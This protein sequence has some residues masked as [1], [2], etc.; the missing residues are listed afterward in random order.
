MRRCGLIFWLIGSIALSAAEAPIRLAILADPALEKEADLLS[1]RLSKA[2]QIELLERGQIRKILEEQ[3]L[4]TAGLTASHSLKVGKL[5]KAD[6][7][8]IL[9]VEKVGEQSLLAL[10]MVAVD[11]GFVTASSYEDYPLKAQEVWEESVEKLVAAS[12]GKLSV[13][14]SEAVPVTL[15]HLRAQI[16]NQKISAFEASINLLLQRRMMQQKE[17]FVLERKRMEA[18]DWEKELTVEN[19]KFWT[20]GAVIDGSIEFKGEEAVITAKLENRGVKVPPI[21]VQGPQAEVTKLVDALVSKILPLLQKEFGAL[22]PWDTQEEA[23]KLQLECFSTRCAG[24]YELSR[25]CADAVW[26]LGIRDEKSRK[27]RIYAYC[28][29]TLPYRVTRFSSRLNWKRFDL[30]K[31]PQRINL[32]SRMMEMLR[33]QLSGGNVP[34]IA[35]ESDALRLGALML[36]GCYYYQVHL[37]LPEQV[38]ELRR[39]VRE[40][41]RDS[42]C[43]WDDKVKTEIASQFGAYWCETPEEAIELYKGIFSNLQDRPPLEAIFF[44]D[45]HMIYSGD[46]NNQKYSRRAL[47][48]GWKNQD[49]TTLISLIESLASWFCA[50]NDIEKQF[51]GWK[52]RERLALALNAKE[53]AH[54]NLNGFLWSHKEEVVSR[55]NLEAGKEQ[56]HGLHTFFDSYFMQE[57]LDVKFVEYLLRHSTGPSALYLAERVIECSREYS[58]DDLKGCWEGFRVYCSLRVRATPYEKQILSAIE[59]KFKFILSEGSD[60][61]ISLRLGVKILPDKNVE[62]TDF[63]LTN[64]QGKLVGVTLLNKEIVLWDLARHSMDRS[65]RF[66]MPAVDRGALYPQMRFSSTGDFAVFVQGKSIFV[67]DRLLQKTTTYSRALDQCDALFIDGESLFMSESSWSG[68]KSLREMNTAG[69]LSVLNLKNGEMKILCSN[70]SKGNGSFDNCDPYLIRAIRKM[71]NDHLIISVINRNLPG[72]VGDGRLCKLKLSTGGSFN[73]VEVSGFDLFKDNASGQYLTF[74]SNV[75]DVVFAI[76]IKTGKIIKLLDF[77][78]NNWVKRPRAPLWKTPNPFI[79]GNLK[80]AIYNGSC[81]YLFERIHEAQ[82][83]IDRVWVFDQKGP[84]PQVIELKCNDSGMIWEDVVF[85]DD[86]IAIQKGVGYYFVSF[87]EIQAVLKGEIPKAAEIPRGSSSEGN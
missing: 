11:P 66:Q 44:L 7:L 74:H 55:L 75:G 6:G 4:A 86:G 20:A 47:L 10:R 68:G 28:L 24:L 80:G 8:L 54:Q 46:Q 23:K 53:Q 16:S 61:K 40:T 65:F 50:S 25:E 5:L 48:P 67:L 78:Q 51:I 37:I 18:L 76:D 32:A 43:L 63:R 2:P 77:M 15:L 69:A 70:R 62:S 36:D 9:K 82:K 71:D 45:T 59:G 13:S 31:E 85:L 64:C 17:V 21:Q 52:L 29:E 3:K 38:A 27:D 60:E 12:K 72:H 39:L 19:Q 35:A 41:Y 58:R 57:K 83:K 22:P 84:D 14:R 33:A 56:G 87:Q 42:Q 1:V 34:P 49:A 30:T 26:A 79:I 73:L 81:L